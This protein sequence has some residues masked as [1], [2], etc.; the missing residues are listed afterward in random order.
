MS[1]RKILMTFHWYVSPALGVAT[2]FV[3]VAIGYGWFA[4][5][6]MPAGLSWRWLPW[7]FWMGATAGGLWMFVKMIVVAV[8]L[9]TMLRSY[10]NVFTKVVTDADGASR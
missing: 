1:A 3:T 7:L 2:F 9:F 8:Q 4:V 10:R 6:T 5:A